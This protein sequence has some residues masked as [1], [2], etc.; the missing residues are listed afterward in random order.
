M[1]KADQ[2]LKINGKRLPVFMSPFT[3][4]D[5]DSIISMRHT[6]DEFGVM[7]NQ[8]GKFKIYDFEKAHIPN[9]N[10][11]W[12]VD[13]SVIKSAKLLGLGVLAFYAY[14]LA[15]FKPR[16]PSIGASADDAL[17]DAQLN[18]LFSFTDPNIIYNGNGEGF[19]VEEEE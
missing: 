1:R 8:K 12:N 18:D 14:R 11:L 9:I 5:Y 13:F 10:Y 19:H 3:K 15:T 7:D 2:I 17:K 4:S 16:I 6:Y